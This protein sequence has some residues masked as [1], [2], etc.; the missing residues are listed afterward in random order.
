MPQEGSWGDKLPTSMGDSPI[1][2]GRAQG[3]RTFLL[4]LAVNGALALL[5][6]VVG[7]AVG[8]PALLAD[9]GHSAGDVLA[10]LGG[11]IGFRWSF[12]P[13]DEDHHYGHG[14][15]EALVG[16]VI[17]LLLAFGGVMLV[18]FAVTGAYDPPAT[19]G[20]SAA[21]GVALLSI[22]ANLGLAWVTWRASRALNSP[23]LRA[24]AR[25]NAGDMLSSLLVVV[26][27]WG[28]MHGWLNA[29]RIAAGLIGVLVIWMGQH[30]VREG[31]DV[32]MDRI[33]DPAIRTGILG[34]AA[35]VDGVITVQTVRV[36]PLGATMRVDME[37]SVDG[38]LTVSKGHSIAHAVEDAVR[39]AHPVVGEVS[40][41]IN[42]GTTAGS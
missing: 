35:E 16:L 13:P 3:Q 14:N 12:R 41:H 33:A 2:A 24:L 1:E 10:S 25:D 29:E 30:S 39:G 4:G 15:M 27:V 20:A 11:L 23:S 31:F 7:W 21:I 8:S 34:T 32:L 5:K 9:A 40:V 22:L 17:G 38:D 37:I 6:G 18:V 28:S 42:P 19:A 36:H 26:G